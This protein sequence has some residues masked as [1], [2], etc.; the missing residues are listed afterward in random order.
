M[1]FIRS[2]KLEDTKGPMR[3][4]VAGNDGVF[5]EENTRDGLHSSLTMRPLERSPS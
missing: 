3:D 1:A 5:R 2:T 4:L